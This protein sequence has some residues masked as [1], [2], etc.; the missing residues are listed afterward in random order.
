L[1]ERIETMY[2]MGESCHGIGKI[3]DMD[4]KLISRMLKGAGIKIRPLYKTRAP[5]RFF[6]GKKYRKKKDDGYWRATKKPTTYLHVDVWEFSCGPLPENWEVHHE[7][8]DKNCNM[9][10]NLKGMPKPEHGRQHHYKT[11]GT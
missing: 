10:C 11:R 1:Q 5:H 2:D 8:H 7:N 3:L 4:R 6:N 9:I